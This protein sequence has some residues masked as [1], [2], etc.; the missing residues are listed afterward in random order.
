M[1]SKKKWIALAIVFALVVAA[2]AGLRSTQKP[3]AKEVETAEESATGAESEP[4]AVAEAETEEVF[5]LYDA[6]EQSRS[7]DVSSQP[8]AEPEETAQPGKPR[9]EKGSKKKKPSKDSQ[10]E[11]DKADESSPDEAQTEH[12]DTAKESDANHKEVIELP[13]IP[14]E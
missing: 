13:E 4:E 8:G 6:A 3:T 5:V 7:A 11:E 9:P 1:S 12:G 10:S 2:A 14:V